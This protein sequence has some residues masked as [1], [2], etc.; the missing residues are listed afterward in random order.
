MGGPEASRPDPDQ[1]PSERLT[2]AN[3]HLTVAPLGDA[4]AVLTQLRDA[5]A[6]AKS[7]G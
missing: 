5:F 1:N 6:E 2:Q 7:A 4:A 3:L